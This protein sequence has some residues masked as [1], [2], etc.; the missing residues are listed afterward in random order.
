MQE[1]MQK[2]LGVGC[3]PDLESERALGS[4]LSISTLH[5]AFI[6]KGGEAGWE[7]TCISKDRL[8]LR[9][10]ESLKF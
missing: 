4:C 10:N 8:Y 2:A 7:D 3:G 6:A 5:Y 9:D 1:K